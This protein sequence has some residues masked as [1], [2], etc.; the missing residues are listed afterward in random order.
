MRRDT[1]CE[2]GGG[3]PPAAAPAR[4]LRPP[5]P[6]KP[7]FDRLGGKPAVE[8]VVDEFL[9]RVAADKRINGRFFNTD[10]ARLRALLVEFVCA[11]TGGP[12]TYRAAT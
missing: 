6:P 1:G 3:A 12:C 7:L 8:A 9:S 5:A 4:P 11:A 10:V 2:S